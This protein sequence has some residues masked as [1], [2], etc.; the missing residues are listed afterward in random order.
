[1]LGAPE[2]DSILQVGSHK[3]REDRQ[4]H[5]SPIEVLTPAPAGHTSSDAAQDVVGCQG[6]KCT[7]SNPVKPLVHQYHQVLLLRAA[8]SLY[9]AC[10]VLGIALTQVQDLALVLVGLH[11][12]HTGH[13]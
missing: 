13:L 6:A 7:L 4:K 8:V 2:L 11:E 10:I 5:P 3:S 9:T 12:V 1:M